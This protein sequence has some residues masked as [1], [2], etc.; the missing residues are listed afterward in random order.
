MNDLFGL[1]VLLLIV[2]LPIW[3]I[4]KKFRKAKAERQRLQNALADM[5]KRLKELERENVLLG[6]EHL[7]FQL[8]PHTLNNILASLKAISNKL[9]RGMDAL[10]STLEYILYRG[11]TNLVTIDEEITFIRTYVDLNE[12]FLTELEP[13]KLDTSELGKH[14]AFYTQPCIP[15]LISAYFIENAFKHGDVN[16]PEFM[17]IRVKLD[18]TH[19]QLHVSNRIRQK[20]ND[21]VGGLGLQ[22]M[23]KR[24]ALLMAGR[25]TITSSSDHSEY[26]AILTLQL[27]P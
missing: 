9:S 24:L 19:F 15:H 2:G 27:N 12:L 22:N 16:H 26:H 25:Y 6:T 20:P 4:I 5:E 7:K 11:R 14:S 8:Q 17:R 23:E 21:K 3:L 13:I 18:N 1:L 10:S